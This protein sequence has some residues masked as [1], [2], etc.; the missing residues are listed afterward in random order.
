MPNE[1]FANI[2]L[3]GGL[4]RMIAKRLHPYIRIARFDNP[5]GSWLLFWPCA[6]GL[7]L[8]SVQAQ[9][10]P[11]FYL[12]S[13]F[14][15]GAVIMRGA[16]CV[17]NDLIDRNFDGQVARTKN[18]PLPSGQI[19]VLHAWLFLCTLCA[20]GF[21]ILIQFDIATIALGFM[22]LALV[23]IY[24]FMKRIT[25]WPQFFLGLAFN[26]GA[27]MGY[28]AHWGD[29]SMG[30]IMLYIGGIFWTMGY[31]T[32]YAHQDKE[33]DAILGIK[34]S[35]RRLGQHSPIALYVFYTLT[36]FCCGLAIWDGALGAYS[37]L[38]LAAAG[39]HLFWQI[40]RLDI[41][42]SAL[43]LRLFKSNREFGF[44]LWLAILVGLF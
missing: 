43:C 24:P 15:L 21:I 11:S 42:N 9:I 12:L 17:Y 39:G 22:S 19:S 35:A 41:D 31:D 26:W 7:S 10:W 3:M 5:I 27:L 38:G 25:W 16:G 4:G 28:A 44:L 33:D 30:A 18:R 20:I 32:I 23:A 6:W 13:L 29:I 2:T 34:S 37:W 40:R 14:G 1:T 36:L 8:A